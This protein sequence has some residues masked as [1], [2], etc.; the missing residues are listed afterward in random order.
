MPKP[1]RPSELGRWLEMAFSQLA[2]DN[3]APSDASA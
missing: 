1:L 2:A 3:L